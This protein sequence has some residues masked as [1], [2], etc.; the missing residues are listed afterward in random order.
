MHRRDGQRRDAARSGHPGRRP[1]FGHA[2]R[3]TR[4]GSPPG[5]GCLRPPESAAASAFFFGPGRDHRARSSSIPR[6]T[7]ESRRSRDRSSHAAR[8]GHRRIL[9]R[10]LL[11][12]MSVRAHAGGLPA[13]NEIG[14]L[15][16]PR[17]DKLLAMFSPPAG[18]ALANNTPERRISEA[19]P[20]PVHD[21]RSL[22]GQQCPTL[23]ACRRGGWT[24]RGRPRSW[25]P[26]GRRS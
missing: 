19:Q 9:P 11:A 24:G 5:C 4:T 25:Q 2:P 18:R 26:I 8:S 15:L 7:S 17:A 12:C 10:V 13:R 22:P 20:Q 16:Q 3:S 14:T 1:A 21:P 23:D 6:A